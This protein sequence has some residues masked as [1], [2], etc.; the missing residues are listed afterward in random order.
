MVVAATY[1][2]KGKNKQTKK[3]S[4]Q[5]QKGICWTRGKSVEFII[6]L[7]LIIVIGRFGSVWEGG[8]K[9][10]HTQSTYQTYL[11]AQIPCFL[12]KECQRLCLLSVTLYVWAENRIGTKS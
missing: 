7:V 11:V 8:W 1:V 3:N 9:G 6:E 10:G 4:H 5:I 12:A 2:G